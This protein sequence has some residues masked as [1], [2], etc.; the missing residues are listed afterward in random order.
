MFDTIQMKDIR[1]AQGGYDYYK[2][3]KGGLNA[4]QNEVDKDFKGWV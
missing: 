3:R 4:Q 1:K 2:V